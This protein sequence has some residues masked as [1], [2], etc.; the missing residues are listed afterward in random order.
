MNKRQ[1]NKINK[2]KG[3]NIH[4]MK[5][6][7]MINYTELKMLWWSC[8]KGKEILDLRMYTHNSK[9]AF[10]TDLNR[11]GRYINKKIGISKGRITKATHLEYTI[12]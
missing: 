9:R 2:F 12:I 11:F 8:Y 5:S 1:K 4:L 10:H 3:Y 6:W 7:D